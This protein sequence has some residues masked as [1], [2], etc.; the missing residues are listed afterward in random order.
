MDNP[1]EAAALYDEAILGSFPVQAV[2]PSGRLTEPDK[3]GTRYLVT[4]SG[5][6][7]EVST[8]WFKCYQVIARSTA[9]LPYGDLPVLAGRSEAVV[10][11]TALQ[12]VP[13]E[14]WEQFVVEAKKAMPNECAGLFVYNPVQKSW[15]LVMRQAAVANSAYIEYREPPLAIDEEMAVDIHSHASFG[16]S[17]SSTDDADDRDSIKI[18]A[19]IGRIDAPVQEVSARV[20]CLGSMFPLDVLAGGVLSIKGEGNG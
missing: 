5:L 10:L 16:A 4:A 9:K 2:P 15:R 14:L 1:V 17:F 12:S 13:K 20:C 6:V 8:R 7:K 19:V 11:N 3:F 18:A